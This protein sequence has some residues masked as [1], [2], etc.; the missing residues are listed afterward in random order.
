M[1]KARSSAKLPPYVKWRDGRPRWE[2]G[3]RGGKALIDAGF[4]SHDLKDQLGNWLTFE[5]AKAAGERLARMV[6]LV[7]DKT[8]TDAATAAQIVTGA[9]T[10]GQGETLTGAAHSPV[11]PAFGS[12]SHIHADPARVTFAQAV[13]AFQ[14]D[15]AFRDKA[16]STRRIYRLY[17]DILC[18]WIGDVAISALRTRDTKRLIERLLD[19][20]FW[21]SRQGREGRRAPPPSG[22]W[23]PRFLALPRAERDRLADLRA[24]AIEA[25]L[26]EEGS[27]S[28]A[29][30][31]NFG[32]TQVHDMMKFAATLTGWAID[33][34]DL[35]MRNVFARRRMSSPAGRARIITP[36]ELE[37]LVTTARA[38]GRPELGTLYLAAV[39]TGQRLTDILE[40]LTWRCLEAGTFTLTQQKTGKE[41]SGALTDIFRRH[42]EEER[43]RFAA[44]G[45]APHPDT[46]LIQNSQTGRPFPNAH[47]VSELAR[48]LRRKAADLVPECED[49]LIH[50]GRDTCVTRMIL[51]GNDVMTIC[52]QTGHQPSQLDMIA[53]HY[54]GSHKLFAQKLAGSLDALASAEGWKY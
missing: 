27:Y 8:A 6:R 49:A 13:A 46:P 26:E 10:G 54:V 17:G 11:T 39:H 19:Q 44:A 21:I 29:V 35:D 20:Q 18:Q 52:K 3:G 47:Y 12:A 24:A 25:A 32:Y 34:F 31:R 36:E 48:D 43:A 40:R 1:K 50:D 30:T 28:R 9:D 42:L 4:R 41:V 23:T 51:A 15:K 2:L 33:H 45:I 53:R 14:A 7:R 37:A 38:E 5:E 16:D 22:G